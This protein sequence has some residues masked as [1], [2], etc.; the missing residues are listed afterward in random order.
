MRH[1]ILQMALVPHFI[2]ADQYPVI[3]VEASRLP[4]RAAST[5][6]IMA[7]EISSE[8]L[9]IFCHKTDRR[10]CR[11]QSPLAMAI[12]AESGIRRKTHCIAADNPA[13]PRSACSPQ[14]H[15]AHPARLGIALCPCRTSCQ[16]RWR[17]CCGIA[18][19]RRR[20]ERSR[21][22]HWGLGEATANLSCCEKPGRCWSTSEGGEQKL[23]I[24]G[25]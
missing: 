1:R 18:T 25:R 17:R 3:G 4:I 6:Y 13:G 24:N 22:R 15:S 9:D 8:S 14:P 20:R 7:G 23:L 19:K 5:V 12:Q 11:I 21:C 2:R 10:A 16:S